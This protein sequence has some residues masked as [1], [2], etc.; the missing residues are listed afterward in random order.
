[1]NAERNF[2]QSIIFKYTWE[3]IP[4]LNRSIASFVG[5]LFHKALAC[6]DTWELH[7]NS[8]NRN[9]FNKLLNVYYNSY[10]D[11]QGICA[12]LIGEGI[13]GMGALSFK[14]EN[15][16]LKVP[17]GYRLGQA[18]KLPLESWKL[19][20]GSKLIIWILHCQ[21]DV[22]F[23]GNNLQPSTTWTNTWE[24]ILE[25]DPLDVLFVEKGLNRKHICRST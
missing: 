10:I 20:I 19:K 15:T 14:T 5:K 13:F 18:Q 17:L 1:M 3:L 24:Y 9:A 12:C 22:L 6:I 21:W 16:K 25:K 23:V 8:S 2:L 11:F 7:M 4:E